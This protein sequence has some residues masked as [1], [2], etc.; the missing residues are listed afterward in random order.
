MEMV[1]LGGGRPLCI[2]S[3][4][5]FHGEKDETKHDRRKSWLK[6][7]NRIAVLHDEVDFREVKKPKFFYILPRGNR[8][9]IGG[10]R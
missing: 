8:K 4:L 1:F 6:N 10:I 9:G 7:E 2:G 3:N 5:E